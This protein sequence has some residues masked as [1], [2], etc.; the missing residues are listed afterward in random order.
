[1]PPRIELGTFCVLGRRDNRYTTAPVRGLQNL[2]HKKLWWVSRGNSSKT[3]VQSCICHRRI[4]GFKRL[5]ILLFRKANSR[6]IATLFRLKASSYYSIESVS[7]VKCNFEQ[8]HSFPDLSCKLSK[9]NG[10]GRLKFTWCR[11]GLNWGP[12]ACKADVITATPRHLFVAGRTL[13]V[14]KREW[15]GK[16]YFWKLASRAAIATKETKSL[17]RL[18][19]LL[20]RK[21]NSRQDAALYRWKPAA[22]TQL[23][24][25]QRK[26]CNIE[27]AHFKQHHIF[28]DLSC[29][30][31]K[32]NLF[33]RLKFALCRPGLNWGPSAC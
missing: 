20:I 3:G 27:Q 2:G 18:E 16:V 17:K 19:N 7:T 14:R 23:N 5:E 15:S 6:Q 8:H 1:M 33:R 11:P 4:Q 28:P 31:F 26:N 21:T 10:F 13:D 12:S 22:T 30:L 24:L 9:D 32:D 29:K 25:F